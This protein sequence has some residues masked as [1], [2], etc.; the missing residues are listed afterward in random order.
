MF[1]SAWCLGLWSVEGFLI[2]FQLVGTLQVSVKFSLGMPVWCP[3]NLMNLRALDFTF[4]ESCGSLGRWEREREEERVL[5]GTCSLWCLPLSSLPLSL[6]VI[7]FLF[8][9]FKDNDDVKANKFGASLHLLPVPS[10]LLKT[11]PPH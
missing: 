1:P 6:P 10:F 3:N 7:I 8:V 11:S 4:W 2:P 5:Q 9:S